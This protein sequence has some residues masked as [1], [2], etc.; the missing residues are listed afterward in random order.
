M[1]YPGFFDGAA[2]DCSDSNLLPTLERG[3]A[4]V[5]IEYRLAPQ[6]K[7]G[8]IVADVTAAYKFIQDGS[9]DQALGGGK[10]DGAR[11]VDRKS[12]V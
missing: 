3:L 5:S 9:L 7:L 12:V 4:F 10:V 11:L 8:E 6:V 1:R 2:G